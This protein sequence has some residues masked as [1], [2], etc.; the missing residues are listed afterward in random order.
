[1]TGRASLG[2]LYPW[3][4][5]NI[6]NIVKIVL[7]LNILAA[8]A[9]IFFGVTK[10]GAIG[11]LQASA[12]T[13]KQNA[14]T[15]EGKYIEIKKT[16]HELEKKQVTLTTNEQKAIAA[17][18]KAETDLGTAV[19]ARTKAEGD[20]A[21]AK[22]DLQTLNGQVSSLQTQAQAAGQ[23]Q[24]QL[25]D[26]ENLGLSAAEITQRLNRLK[27]LEDAAKPPP[28][29]KKPKPKVNFGEVGKVGQWDAANQFGVFQAGAD[30]GI[31]VGDKF[32]IFRGGAAIGKIVVQR[33][34][35][36]LSVF[37]ADLAF[38]QPQS[39]YKIGDSVMKTN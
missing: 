32:T 26:F 28:V 37:K 5:G 20:L 23:L 38:G 2:Y 7:A 25:T 8:G 34:T 14:D 3:K 30:N 4:E 22:Q 13:A 11:D 29:K 6:G 31:K 21:K 16:F 1:M 17:K 24:A 35:P 10:K 33:V 39:P 27:Q 12:Q 18:I 36:V 19:V 9:G 15:A